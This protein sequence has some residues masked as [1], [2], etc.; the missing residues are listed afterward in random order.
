M[1]FLSGGKNSFFKVGASNLE[2]IG[3]KVILRDNCI[4]DA[5]LDY[6]WRS[7]EELSKL[8]A[9]HPLKM[10]FDDYLKIYKDQLRR[11]S[12]FSRRLSI[13]TISGKYIG[14]C[15]YYNMD[16][17]NRQA[18]VG[19]VIGDRNYWNRGYGYDALITLMEYL[20]AETDLEK[21]YLHTL[22]WNKRAQQAFIKCGFAPII[23]VNRN[24]MDFIKM[25]IQ[26]RDWQ[27]FCVSKLDFR[28]SASNLQQDP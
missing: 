2:L 6:L 20:L 10:K 9:S 13:N 28:D 21:L 4:E 1:K 19:I 8:D 26:K 14:N 25:A 27:E 18:E 24:G 3:G 23:R 12:S 5:W 22:V 17:I 7:D 15:M 16:S 11:P